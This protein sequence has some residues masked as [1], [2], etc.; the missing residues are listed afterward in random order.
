MRY[1]ANPVIVDA[2]TILTVDPPAH[3]GSR[4]LQLDDGSIVTAT[5]EMLARMTPHVGD[6]WIIQ[7]DG[8]IY[9]NPKEVFERK[10]SPIE[11]K[12]LSA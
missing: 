1:R 8:Y 2:F 10:Y 11:N 12:A 4:K 7:E 5:P 3:D 6:Y 9:L